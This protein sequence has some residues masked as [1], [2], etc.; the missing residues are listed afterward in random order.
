MT[1][2]SEKFSS[3]KERERDQFMESPASA[4]LPCV[5]RNSAQFSDTQ[6]DSER[7]SEHSQT[8]KQSPASFYKVL[9]SLGI[10]MRFPFLN[11]TGLIRRP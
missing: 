5:Q 8:L 9:E 10:Y 6:E 2:N 1:G 4:T 7:D 3:E 11:K